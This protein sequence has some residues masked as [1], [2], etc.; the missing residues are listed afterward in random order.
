VKR[1]LWPRAYLWHNRLG[2]IITLMTLLPILGAR[3]A[4]STGPDV[5]HLN[6]EQKFRAADAEARLSQDRKLAVGRARYQKRV[7]YERS[8][9]AGMQAE[10]AQRSQTVSLP[11]ATAAQAPASAST[12][13]GLPFAVVLLTVGFLWHRFG[14]HLVSSWDK[15]E[16]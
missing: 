4:V 15:P 11:P 7:A 3:G 8:L 1:P 10:L 5:G 9:I 16:N 13:F 14:R 12:N 6:P 2:L